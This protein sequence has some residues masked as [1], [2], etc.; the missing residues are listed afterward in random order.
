MSEGQQQIDIFGNSPSG[1]QMRIEKLRNRS[2]VC[3][4]SFEILALW[5]RVLLK[6]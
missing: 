3:R 6:C 5:E 1:I 4:D 2:I